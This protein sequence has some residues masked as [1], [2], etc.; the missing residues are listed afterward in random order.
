MNEPT[1]ASPERSFFTI[2]SSLS[3]AQFVAGL[4]Q[5]R[6]ASTV[7]NGLLL[8]IQMINWLADDLME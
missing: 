2:M 7:D 8:L 1:A 5:T 3:P 4:W 6:N